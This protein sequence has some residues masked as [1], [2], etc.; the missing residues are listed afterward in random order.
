MSGNITFWP[1]YEYDSYSNLPEIYY[2]VGNPNADNG[3]YIKSYTPITIQAEDEESDIIALEYRT[4]NSSYRW[5][6]WMNYTETIYLTTEGKNKIECRAIDESGSV[7]TEVNT[8]YVDDEDPYVELISP[9]GGEVLRQV[10]T[11]EWTAADEMA[12]QQQI[13]ESDYYS[14]PADYPGH[15]QSF[16]PTEPYINSVELLMHGDHAE[17]TVTIF[18]SIDPIPVPI[19]TTSQIVEHNGNEAWPEWFSF[20]L[21]DEIPVDSDNTY[22]L[23][24]SQRILGNTGM[25]WH[26]YNSSTGTD[27]YP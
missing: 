11:I 18:E 7:R 25:K 14:L 17:V 6:E 22:Y 24:V 4:W 19:A 16:T 13:K 3:D 9:T 27:P 23:G 1:W 8:H 21:Q 10:A 26:Y 20:P 2:E 15:L 5:S 12:D